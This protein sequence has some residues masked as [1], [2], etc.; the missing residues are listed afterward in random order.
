MATKPG[1]IG[2]DFIQSLLDKTDLVQLIGESVP[3]KK[4]GANYQACCPFHSEKT[5]SFTVSPTKQFF[6][7]FG[8]GA[9]GDAIHF[10]RKMHGLEFIEAV[11]Q[12]AQKLGVELPKNT[13]YNR[14]P[15][16]QPFVVLLGKVSQFYQKAL[17]QHPQK[18]VAVNYLKSRGITGVTAKE[19]AIGYAPKEWDNLVQQ[20]QDTP[21]DLQKLETLGLII[22]HQKG[23]HFDRFRNRIMYPIRNRK[24]EVIGFG[25]R[26]LSHQDN[27]K[28]M[29]SPENAVFK[30]GLH[31]YGI[32]EALAKKQEWRTVIC[33]EGYMDV[34]GLYQ[35]GVYGA[36]ATM[37][38]AVS[39][40]HIKQLFKLS[41]KIVFCFDG[42]TAGRKAAW[43]ALETLFPIYLSQKQIKF[44]F[45]PEGE[46]PDSYIK[47]RGKSAFLQLLHQ[48]LSFSEYFFSELCNR[49]PP[50]NVE[51]RAQLI[52]LGKQYIAQ[53]P[54]AAYKQLMSEALAQLTATSEQ[55]VKHY[56]GDKQKSGYQQGGYKARNYNQRGTYNKHY[57]NNDFRQSPRTPPPS[58]LGPAY[59]A[60]ALL[61]LQPTLLNDIHDIARFEA[62]NIPGLSLFY[63]VIGCLESNTEQAVAEMVDILAERGFTRHLIN[64]CLQKAQLI[65]EAGRKE[66]FL[67]ALHRVSVI[68]HEQIIENLLKKA[69]KQELSEE[70][71]HCL[72]KFLQSRESS[73]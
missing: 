15:Q 49:Y 28:Y 17:R 71:K 7:C 69:E 41:N 51:N 55:V 30:K 14:A 22:K 39:E 21:E 53:L 44:L 1:Y 19:F 12:L 62:Y 35:Q 59:I 66:E 72:K 23:H 8:C 57:K 38:T 47:A 46:D 5:P 13:Q 50:N 33:V 58:P 65:P 54:D 48:S 63:A 2:E 64:Q 29:N 11:E 68:G 32:Y 9:N 6:H 52:N 45:L 34:I 31:L 3:L 73:S 70:E 4:A 10:L 20:W 25:G 67:G 42:D 36:L 56:R 60:S 27:P 43:K 24:G 26:V 18:E 40:H 16:H 61:L 37:G